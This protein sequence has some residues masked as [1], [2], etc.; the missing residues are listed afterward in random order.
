LS[1]TV[2]GSLRFFSALPA[3]ASGE[4]KLEETWRFEIVSSSVGFSSQGSL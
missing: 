3:S 4:M 1:A 2:G